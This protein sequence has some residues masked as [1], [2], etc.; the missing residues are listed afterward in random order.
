[1]IVLSQQ[2]EAEIIR[3]IARKA[4]IK[5]AN[6]AP[7]FEIMTIVVGAHCRASNLQPV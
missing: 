2:I 6:A 3:K 7:A 1:L 5:K 4:R